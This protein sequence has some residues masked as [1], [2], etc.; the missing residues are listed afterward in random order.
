MN[1]TDGII[2]AG[3]TLLFGVLLLGCSE[4]SAPP[5]NP[6]TNDPI[7]ERA[8]PADAGI[9]DTAAMSPAELTAA[10]RNIPLLPGKDCNLE[11]VND[12]V[13]AGIPIKVPAGSTQVSV[14][15]WLA[16]TES[17]N[18]PERAQL[19]LVSDQDHRAWKVDFNTG[20]KREDVLKLLGGNPS[21]SGAGFM[22]PLSVAN[23]PTG[24]YRVYTVFKADDNLKVCD[25]GRSIALEE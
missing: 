25:N 3:A 2:K 5:V 14:S 24:T 13:F 17:A 11:R 8:Q 15:G 18:I 16:D 6:P 12:E 4:P 23:L 21:Y 9:S 19:R 7:H 20:R 22:V 10:E 1:T